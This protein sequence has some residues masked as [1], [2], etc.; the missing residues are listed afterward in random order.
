M[1]GLNGCKMGDRCITMLCYTNDAVLVAQVSKYGN[2][3]LKNQMSD[4]F[5]NRYKMQACHRTQN[6]ATRNDI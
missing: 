3:C 2:I 6:N 4:N 5:K 1:H